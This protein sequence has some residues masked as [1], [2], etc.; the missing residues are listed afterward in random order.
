MAMKRRPMLTIEHDA[1]RQLVTLD[2][3]DA[4]HLEA[5]EMR[6]EQQRPARRAPSRA[7]RARSDPA[8]WNECVAG[9]QEYA[10]ERDAR[11]R[12]NVTQHVAEA[13]RDA[14]TRAR[15]IRVSM[16]RVVRE[17]STKYRLSG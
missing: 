11:E 2:R 4:H 17:V 6:Q 9:E 15:G 16:R 1:Q 8:T 3:A 13:R 5:A 7:C 12:K 14:A 10:V